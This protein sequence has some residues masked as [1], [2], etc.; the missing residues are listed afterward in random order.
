MFDFFT[1]FF[2]VLLV[3]EAV[4]GV[5]LIGWWV[6]QRSDYSL[7]VWGLLH[8]VGVLLLWGSW[9]AMGS[10]LSQ[11]PHADLILAGLLLI[12]VVPA[13]GYVLF[14][15]LRAEARLRGGSGKNSMWRYFA[16]AEPL[17]AEQLARDL[18]AALARPDK[19]LFLHYQPIFNAATRSISGFEAL[20]RWEHPERGT[21]SPSQ[22]IP[23]AEAFGIILPLGRWVLESACATAASW[24]KPWSVSVNVSPMQLKQHRF[25]RHVKEALRHSGLAP[26]RLYLEV[27]EG[28]MIDSASVVM[29]RLADLRDMGAKVAIDDFGTGY[30][31]LRYLER[32]PCD[33]IKIDRS[34]VHELEHDQAARAIAAAIIKLSQELGHDVVAE[35][36]ETEGQLNEL[37]ILGCQRVQGW[38]LGR[39]MKADEIVPV[40]GNNALYQGGRELVTEAAWRDVEDADDGDRADEDRKNRDAGEADAHKQ[41]GDPIASAEIL[42]FPEGE[43]IISRPAKPAGPH[44][45]VWEVVEGGR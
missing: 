26:E 8:G 28:I 39:P 35:G 29:S 20:L 43:Q 9:Y 5:F 14:R 36:V 22:F 32:L 17:E 12:C 1:L 33:T 4:A 11:L 2:V 44:G 40:F 31:S 16:S 37:N 30:S 10:R 45:M 19:Q 25:M 23:I 6:Q 13:F 24:P 38:L 34:F 41:G 3:M 27:T 18:R 7:A 42:P 15:M 21:I